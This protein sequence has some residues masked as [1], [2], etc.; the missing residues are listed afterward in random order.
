MFQSAQWLQIQ[1]FASDEVRSQLLTYVLQQ[2]PNFVA[3]TTSTGENDYRRSM[4]LYDFPEFSNW[5]IQQV[6]SNLPEV[7]TQLNLTP[8]APSQIE[9]Q[10]T[11][12][13]DG[14]YYK[15]HN[16][17][18]SEDAA[19]RTISYVYYFY[20]E[21]KGFSGGELRLYDLAVDNSYYI[22]ADSHHTIEPF[23]NSI[24]FFP[25]HLMHEVMPVVC[26]SRSFADS[27]FTLNGWIRQ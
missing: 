18:G 2:T 27:R 5:M 9:V 24:I 4:I 12:H 19:T 21:P 14:N 23:N 20:R 17:N 22:Q 7:F 11:A 16:D 26:P 3:T 15:V 10:L 6:A 13:N 1:N 8:F 25:S